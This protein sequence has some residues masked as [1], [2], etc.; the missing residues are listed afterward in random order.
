MEKRQRY[1]GFRKFSIRTRLI[2]ALFLI[3]IVPLTGIS[4][5]SFHIFS[6]ALR[7]KLSTSI[8]QTLSMINLNMVSEIEK[9]QYLCGSICISQEIKDGLL[10]K[11][12]TDTEKNQAINEIQH[13]IR[14]K[15][16]Y[17][18]QAKNITVYDTDGNIFYDLG[19]DGLYSDDVSRILSRLEEEN[20]DVWAYA[21]T[22]RNRDILILG[23]RIYEQYSQ[24]RV[25][26]YTLISI[27]EKI[28][29]KT[30]TLWKS[31]APQ[32]LIMYGKVAIIMKIYKAK[33]Y[34]ELSRKAASII[35]SQV[36][37]K[38][39]CVLG[40]ATG[41]T[42]IGT[43]KQLIEWYNK[44]D[45]DFSSVKSV[46]LDEYRGLAPTHTQSYR[47]FMQKNLF[48]H[49]DI[50]QENTYVPNGMAQDPEEEC[51]RYDSMLRALGGTDLQLLGLGRNGHIGFNEPGP[52]FIKETHVV[53]LSQ[54]TIE[55][56]ARFFES[57]DEVPRQAITMGIGC[58]MEARRVLVAVSGEDKAEAV[59]RSFCGPITPEVPGSILQLHGDVVLVG[60]RAALS[61]LPDTSEE[62]C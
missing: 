9:Y 45:L 62:A 21:H 36:L 5:Y 16:I 44:G 23:R 25:I 55:A 26:G 41:S 6:E 19:Y 38:P 40:L 32:L 27:D 22:Y 15:I 46:N 54:S 12:M 33:D 4:F 8:S 35:A 31:G 51:S 39:D 1:Q 14:S 52:A 37:M 30:V 49:I 24:S 28:F 48:D 43:Y 34:D 13:M 53:E 2:I 42:P 57:A 7:E 20:Q 59:Y 50:R 11:G 3:S 10:K 47:D 17:P 58:I 29:S 60:D 56:N 61:R 18:A